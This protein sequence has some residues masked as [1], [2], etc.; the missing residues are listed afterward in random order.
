[1]TT[2][3]WRLIDFICIP[4]IVSIDKNQIVEVFFLDLPFKYQIITIIIK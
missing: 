4:F 2:I 3:I 1:M